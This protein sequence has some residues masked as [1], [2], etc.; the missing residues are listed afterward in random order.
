MTGILANKNSSFSDRVCL[1]CATKIITFSE[2][3][4][5]IVSTLKAEWQKGRGHKCRPKGQANLA[6]FSVNATTLLERKMSKTGHSSA[7]EKRS[8]AKKSL[9]SQFCSRICENEDAI[10]NI[11]S[12]VQHW[13][14]QPV[15]N[16]WCREPDVRVPDEKENIALLK[17][18]TLKNWQFVANAVP[19]HSELRQYIQ[20]ALISGVSWKMSIFF[21]GWAK[22]QTKV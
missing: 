10:L 3:F 2:G 16:L 13:N 14:S 1:P 5:F 20:K 19:K 7:R 15:W 17:N 22:H 11:D 18:I 9:G 8:S 6:D 21:F 12:M 4:N